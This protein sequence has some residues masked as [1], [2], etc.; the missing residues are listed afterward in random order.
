MVKAMNYFLGEA[1]VSISEVRL[2][3]EKFDIG[4]NILR[5]FFFFFFLNNLNNIRNYSYLLLPNQPILTQ[6]NIF[7]KKM[8]SW[9]MEEALDVDKLRMGIEKFVGTHNFFNFTVKR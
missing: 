9:Q 2:V 7:F 4:K 8:C 6:K 3:D 1:D 5:K